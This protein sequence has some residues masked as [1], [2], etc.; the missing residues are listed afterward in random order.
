M[1]T[2]VLVDSTKNVGLDAIAAVIDRVSA[3]TG[4][5][6]ATGANEVTGGSY[7]RQTP[8]WSAAAFGVASLSGALTFSVPACTISYAGL[9]TNAGTVFRGY[10]VLPTPRVFTGAGTWVVDDLDLSLAND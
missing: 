2:C 10:V 9:W 8:T 3:H 5:P 1:S 6:G 4:N 7:A